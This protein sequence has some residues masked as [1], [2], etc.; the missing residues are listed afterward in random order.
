[1]TH[2]IGE[3][4]RS[5]LQGSS[6]FALR[7]VGCEYWDGVLT[8]QGRLPTYYLKQ[9]AQ[10]MVAEVEG[11]TAV[12]NRIEVTAPMPRAPSGRG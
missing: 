8:L 7:D 12:V 9:I 1:M 2:G 3:S 4:A 5:R 6:Y 11:V 10:T